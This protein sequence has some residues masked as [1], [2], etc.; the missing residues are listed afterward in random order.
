VFRR[1]FIRRALGLAAAAP[2]AAVA[3]PGKGEPTYLKNYGP[4]AHLPVYDGK[5][6]LWPGIDFDVDH[7]RPWIGGYGINPV[8]RRR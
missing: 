8:L 6:L 7:D 4:F 2:V 1:D 5:R 3:A